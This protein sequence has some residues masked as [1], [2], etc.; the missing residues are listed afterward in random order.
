VVFNIKARIVQE[1]RWRAEL[2]GV[3]LFSGE[4]AAAAQA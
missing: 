1:K 4:E 3:L 2:S